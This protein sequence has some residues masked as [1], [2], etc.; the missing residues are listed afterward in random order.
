MTEPE[1]LFLDEP[2]SGLDS[3]AALR[4]IE[5]LKKVAV[6]KNAI[7]CCTVHQPSSELFASFDRV[8]CLR[9]GEVLFQGLNDQSFLE[10][11]T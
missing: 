4:L 10:Q 9:E 11:I 6:E 2:T 3:F 7:V 8:L 1:F 5:N